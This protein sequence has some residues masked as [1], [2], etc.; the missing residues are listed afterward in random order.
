[1]FLT[2]YLYG[3]CGPKLKIP[4][5]KNPLN[6]QLKQAFGASVKVLSFSLLIKP[7]NVL[8]DKIGQNKNTSKAD[9]NLYFILCLVG[10]NASR[11]RQVL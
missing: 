7:S 11:S 3:G 8:G 2:I 6:S 1:M 10:A 9:V 5:Y 4:F